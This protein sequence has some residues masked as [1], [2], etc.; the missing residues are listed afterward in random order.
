MNYQNYFSFDLGV[1]Q[2]DVF[3]PLLFD[4]LLNDFEK[5][6]I[7]SCVGLEYSSD[8]VEKI[9]SND[10]ISVFRKLFV[11]VICQRYNTSESNRKRHAN[12]GGSNVRTSP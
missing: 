4:L 1:R 11:T 6:L 12:F 10:D 2:G 8:D 9:S 7:N 3:S 5:Y